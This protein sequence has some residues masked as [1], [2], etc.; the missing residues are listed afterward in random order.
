MSLSRAHSAVRAAVNQP[1]NDV[2]AFCRGRLIMELGSA[3]ILGIVLFLVI[4]VPYLIF[5]M[6]RGKARGHTW[7][8][9]RKPL[10][11]S[12]IGPDTGPRPTKPGVDEAKGLRY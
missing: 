3:W 4:L 8:T 10:G 5:E 7:F 11:H 9:R 6:K 1:G 2:A 12:D